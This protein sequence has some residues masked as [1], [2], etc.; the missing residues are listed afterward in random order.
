M[1]E[2]WTIFVQTEHSSQIY[3]DDVEVQPK[4]THKRSGCVIDNEQ[5]KVSPLGIPFFVCNW[6]LMYPIDTFQAS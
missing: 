4:I 2:Q 5:K 1:N 3:L 6:L